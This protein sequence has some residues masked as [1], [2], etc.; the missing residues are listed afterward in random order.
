VRPRLFTDSNGA[1]YAKSS[2]ICRSR[3]SDTGLSDEPETA[4][5]HHRASA[6][7]YA[8]VADDLGNYFDDNRSSDYA[9]NCSRQGSGRPNAENSSCGTGERSPAYAAID[10]TDNS[11][12][13]AR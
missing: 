12:H 5:G 7:D 9:A 10:I 8:E 2:R 13:H 11:Q 6:S 4:R 3:Q 1:T